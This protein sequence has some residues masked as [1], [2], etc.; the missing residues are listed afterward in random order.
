MNASVHR[1]RMGRPAT[2]VSKN[3]TVSAIL[4]APFDGSS[5]GI[6]LVGGFGSSYIQITIAPRNGER[7]ATGILEER[8]PVVMT[9]VCR[10]RPQT[11]SIFGG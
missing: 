3:A 4:R 6:D 11:L 5:P 7:P 1:R 2:L 10:R 9:V 8:R